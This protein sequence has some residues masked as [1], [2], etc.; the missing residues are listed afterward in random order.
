MTHPKT[1]GER[2]ETIVLADIDELEQNDEDTAEDVDIDARSVRHIEST[3]RLPLVGLS[4]IVPGTPVEIKAAQYRISDGPQSRFGRF[5]I[6]RK[7]HERLLEDD[8]AYLYA[9]YRPEDGPDDDPE[10][11]ATVL[12]AAETVERYRN[13]WYDVA[14]R[15]TYTQ[16]RWTMFPFEALLDDIDREATVEG[17][18]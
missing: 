11:I 12:V 1:V 7:Q 10:V 18:A 4:E 15:E 16:L 3:P 6:R 5:Q 14:G 9:V 2:L 8:G 17:V 13:D